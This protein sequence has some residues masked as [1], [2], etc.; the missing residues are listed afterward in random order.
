[1][2]SLSSIAG[3]GHIYGDR[4]TIFKAAGLA[5]TTGSYGAFLWVLG[6]KIYAI[7]KMGYSALLRDYRGNFGVDMQCRML[8]TELSMEAWASLVVGCGLKRLASY[9]AVLY[10]L[11]RKLNV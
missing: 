1:M 3:Y 11:D 8:Y 2:D 4:T 6:G 10:G 5:R 9:W 7:A